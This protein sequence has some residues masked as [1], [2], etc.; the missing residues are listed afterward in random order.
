MVPWI[1]RHNVE[2][3]ALFWHP[4]SSPRRRSSPWKFYI[5]RSRRRAGV[6]AGK[7]SPGGA[8]RVGYIRKPLKV[9]LRCWLSAQFAEKKQV[10]RVKE[11]KT[12]S[13]SGFCIPS[14]RAN[15]AYAICSCRTR[16]GLQ[17]PTA[18][19]CCPTFPLSKRSTVRKM[20]LK[21]FVVDGDVACPLEHRDVLQHCFSEFH[22]LLEFFESSENW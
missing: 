2:N 17:D 9:A 22:R 1:T 21:R 8:L 19:P 10:I 20:R 5:V 7:V 18:T 3:F 14:N 12:L 13:T 6:K 4:W 11:Y 15:N 16:T